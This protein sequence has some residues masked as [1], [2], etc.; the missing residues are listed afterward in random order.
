MKTILQICAIVCCALPLMASGAQVDTPVTITDAADSFTLSNGIVT[1]KVQKR[2]GSLMSLVYQGIETL[3]ADARHAAGYW[4]HAASGPQVVTAITIDPHTNAGEYGEVSIKGISGGKP[5]GA[6]PGGSAITDIEIRYTLHRGDSAVFLYCIFE[7]KAEYPATSFG[8]ARF[9]VKLNDDVFDWMTVDSKRSQPAITTYDWNH[10]TVMNMKEARRMTS[11]LYKGEVEH[12]YDYSAVQFETPAIGWSSTKRHV[13]LWLVNP[14]TEYLSGG[15]TKVELCIH[16]DATFGENSNAKAPPCLLNY[17]RGSHYGGSVCSIAAGEQWT[18]VVGPFA[19]YCNTDFTPEAMRKDAL[20][21]TAKQA[22][23]WPYEW[24]TSADY[25]HHSDRSAVNGQIVLTDP[26][27]APTT[28]GQVLVGLTAPDYKV[29]GGRRGQTT[30]D[31]QTDAKHYEFWVRADE[32]GQFVIPNVRPGSY[33]L[34]AIATGVLGEFAKTSVTVAGGKPLDLGRLEWTPVRF[35]RQLWEIGIPDRTAGEFLHGDHF[36]QWGLYNEY[37]KDF[38]NDVNFIIGKSDIH[39]DWNY[40]QCPRS[41]RPAGTPWT[42]TFD[43]ADAPH[44]KATLRVAF[45][46]TSAR[47]LD[48]AVNDQPAGS[49]GPLQDT[50]TIRRDGIRGYWCE[51]AVSFDAALLKQGTNVVKLTIPPGNAMSGI[52]Y[53]Y[54]RLELDDAKGK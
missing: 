51:R 2:S 26:Q 36:W 3:D 44:G 23:A 39:K 14:S 7:H 47:R 29:D 41:D 27:A 11:G 34:H 17:W 49:I 28:M 54:L 13:G 43:Q 45:A 30:V 35:G 15:P 22:S 9:C 4:S 10:G 21:Y 32:K 8:E 25:P 46:A 48:V 33:T 50:A 53:D 31:W 24:V 5:M 42:I 20:A 16:R 19:L 6:G 38:P 1:A 18:K 52:E 37:P 40:C 12:K